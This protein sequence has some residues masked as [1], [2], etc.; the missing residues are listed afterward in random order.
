MPEENE[1]LSRTRE[2]ISD[3]LTVLDAY[4]LRESPQ[5]ITAVVAVEAPN[6]SRSLRF[7]RWRNDDGEWKKDSGFN[8]NRKS[9]WQEIKRSADEMVEG[10]WE[11]EA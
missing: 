1:G 4:I 7:Y 8:I 2:L 9:D 6:E 3:Y 11:G 5:W 10:L